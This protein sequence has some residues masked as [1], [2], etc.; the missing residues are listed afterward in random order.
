[1]AYFVFL[2]V[3]PFSLPDVLILAS[4]RLSL[5]SR[6]SVIYGRSVSLV[7]LRGS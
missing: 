5:S 6:R 1:M 2:L 7:H 4:R 3:H